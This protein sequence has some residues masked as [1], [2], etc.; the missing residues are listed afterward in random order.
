MK[1]D[2][3]EFKGFGGYSK[4]YQISHPDYERDVVAKIIEYDAYSTGIP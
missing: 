2:L 1:L 3:I 4:V